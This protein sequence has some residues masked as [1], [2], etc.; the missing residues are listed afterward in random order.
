MTE[1]FADADAAVYVI[2]VAAQLAGMHPQT[3]RAYD[4]LGLVQPQRT[5][6]RGRR[7]SR[8]DIEALREV[9]ELSQR[10]GVNLE[11]IRRILEL[12]E[13]V[14]VLSDR[15]AATEAAFARLRADTDRQLAAVRADAALRVQA[16][17]EEADRREA[18][19]H[20]LHRRELLPWRPPSAIVIWR[21]PARRARPGGWTHTTIP[22]PTRFAEPAPHQTA[23]QAPQQ[24]PHQTPHQRADRAAG[25]TKDQTWIPN[26]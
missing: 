14:R 9:A 13:Q 21:P 26:A 2:S 1:Q 18:A 20:A 12:Q 17:R 5:P 24:T 4:R 3:L 8:R 6:G 16:A 15:L 23:Y 19:A 25:R 11:G 10:E 22:I 7:Y